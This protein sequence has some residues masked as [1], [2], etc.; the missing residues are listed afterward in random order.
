MS[1]EKGA[2]VLML[3]DLVFFHIFQ[4]KGCIKACEVLGLI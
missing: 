3:K 2:F 4:H 1:M